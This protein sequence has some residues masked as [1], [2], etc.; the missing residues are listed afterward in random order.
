MHNRFLQVYFVLASL[1]LPMCRGDP[2]QTPVTLKCDKIDTYK[3]NCSAPA[4]VCGDSINI[5]NVPK[6]F[7]NGIK[8]T[9]E[10]E[11][12]NVTVIQNSILYMK[13][14]QIFCTLSKYSAQKYA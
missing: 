9:S 6:T 8:N 14:T 5:V 7:C 12:V 2:P 11:Q 10:T 4:P 13:V 3:F 1:F